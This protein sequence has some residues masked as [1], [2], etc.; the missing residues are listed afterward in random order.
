[1]FY[2]F[3]RTILSFLLG[4]FFRRIEVEG[5]AP[6]EEGPVI[7]ASN[8]PNMMIDSM[9]IARTYRREL[10]F[11]AKSTLFSNPLV[12]Q[13]LSLCHVLPI[14][15]RMDGADPKANERTF[16]I[17]SDHLT[18]GK[19]IVIFPEGRS[20]GVRRVLEIKTGA[21]RMGFEAL[22]ATNFEL[23]LRIQPVGITYG[24]PIRFQ[25]TVAIRFGEPIQ[26]Q[27]FEKKFR[28]NPAN[29]VHEVTGLLEG[30]LKTLTV[31]VPEVTFER[32]V[33]KLSQLYQGTGSDYQKL[34]AIVHNVRE[35]AP[36]YPEK[37]VYYESRIDEVLSLPGGD[38]DPPQRVRPL[39]FI[40]LSI[41]ALLHYIP[42]Q[43]TGRLAQK[44]SSEEVALGSNKLTIGVAVF[45]VWYLLIPIF[46]ILFG[47]GLL[48][49]FIFFLLPTSGWLL[50]KHYFSWRYTLLRLVVPRQVRVG[51]LLRQ[52]LIREFDALRVV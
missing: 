13:L 22:E 1:M 17:V 40:F 25:S 5:S 30:L 42:Y 44:L 20:L 28:E 41:A 51:E 48:G 46:A 18:E 49:L 15:R 14:Y 39:F 47:G 4:Q 33:D 45:G 2:N 21:V 23:P 52:E 19:G 9:L 50:N 26:L 35:L 31:E 12:S 29:A 11:L 10:W 16:H 38:S 8:H 27:T 43:F 34:Q 6:L 32:L 24:D 37:L 36:L 3:G 7:I